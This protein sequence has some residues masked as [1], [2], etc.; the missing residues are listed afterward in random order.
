MKALTKKDDILEH[1]KNAIFTT[2]S[3]NCVNVNRIFLSW[4]VF[5]QKS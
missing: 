3:Q 2:N 5:G 4:E 1:F